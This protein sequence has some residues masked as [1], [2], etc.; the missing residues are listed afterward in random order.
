[1]PTDSIE[2]MLS[3]E[4]HRDEWKKRLEQLDQ[5]RQERLGRLHAE[6]RKLSGLIPH[7]GQVLSTTR[8]VEF[9]DEQMAAR[10]ILQDNGLSQS[11]EKV[12]H[13]LRDTS[14]RNLQV[15]VAL[16]AE[17]NRQ[18]ILRRLD[19]IGR[20]PPQRDPH[21]PGHVCQSEIFRHFRGLL[22]HLVKLEDFP[23]HA[24][25]V[26]LQVKLRPSVLPPSPTFPEPGE[27]KS[28]S[29]DQKMMPEQAAESELELEN[30]LRTSKA[31]HNADFTMVD[32]FGTEYQFA[33]GIQS[34][35]VRALWK[36]W[37]KSGLGLHQETIREAIDSERDSFRMDTAFRNHRALGTM[38][39]R[40]GDG[41]YRLARPGTEPD[42]ATPK[43]KRNNKRAPKSRRKRG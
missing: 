31:V 36:E 7:E 24:E 20:R 11:I 19:Q 23:E 10:R 12:S 34:S 38:I 33:L 30:H 21:D 28:P 13:R 37:E 15:A 8:Q 1:M 4:E 2:D 18:G 42:S 16:L 26:E 6:L 43:T 9:A 39:Q 22:G 40:C 29:A 35:V 3:E 41:R 5:S 27:N 17:E 25:S 32:W 14:D